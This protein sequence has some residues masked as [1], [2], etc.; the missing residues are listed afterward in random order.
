MLN[1]LYDFVYAQYAAQTKLAVSPLSTVIVLIGILF[2]G[3][4]IQASVDSIPICTRIQDS[5]GIQAVSENVM[6]VLQGRAYAFHIKIQ[7]NRDTH[8]SSH[9]QVLSPTQMQRVFLRKD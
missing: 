2:R 4:E 6:P 3:G 1:Q 5:V 8:V 9:G 7:T